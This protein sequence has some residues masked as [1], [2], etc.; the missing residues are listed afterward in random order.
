MFALALLAAAA[1]G[2]APGILK[3]FT[4]WTVGCDN[5]RACQAVGLQPEEDTDSLTVVVK[6][7][8]AANARPDIFINLGDLAV[9]AV[10]ADGRR[11][12]IGLV[13]AKGIVS[14]RDEDSLAFIEAIKP[15]KRLGLLDA[16]GREIG[17]ASL[18]GFNAALLYM[19]DQQKRVGTTSALIRKGPSSAVPAPPA[20]PV[21]MSPRVSNAPPRQLTKADIARE[22]KSLHCETY[23]PSEYPPD[24]Q[25][26]TYVRLDA[27]TTLALLPF[28]CGNGAYNFFSYALLIDQKG[29]VTPARFDSPVGM[30]EDP[31][32]DNEAVG[33]GWDPKIRRLTTYGLGRGLGDCGNTRSFAWDGTRFRLVQQAEMDEC[34]GSVDYITTWRAVVSVR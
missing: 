29:T 11:L 8:A 5:G 3:T 34:R 25:E 23:G 18:G 1:T 21:I 30:T 17:H 20:Y 16:R 7:P 9:A 12:A 13:P 4:D 19:D 14:V 10:S 22:T 33:A 15:A 6:R 28:P 31:Y 2:P 26:N 32:F 24:I 27:V